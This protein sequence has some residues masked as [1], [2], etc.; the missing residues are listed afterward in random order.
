[1]RR[2]TLLGLV[3]LGAVGIVLAAIGILPG[4]Q[5][6]IFSGVLIIGILV[7]RSTYRRDVPAN[8]TLQATGEVF[9]DPISKKTVRVLYDPKTGERYYDDTGHDSNP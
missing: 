8:R 3:I 2:G 7:E 9:E 1:M 6:I 4:W 5:L